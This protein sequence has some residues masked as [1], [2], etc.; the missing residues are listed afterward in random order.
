[1]IKTII[2]TGG[3]SSGHVTPNLAL[4]K[5]AEQRGWSIHYL[6]ANGI[7]KDI[8]GK[9]NIPYHEIASGKLRRY[10][11]WQNFID[12]FKI[13]YAIMQSFF[14]LR[15]IKPHCV[16]SKGGFVAVPVVIAAW[17][18]RIPVIA[19]E[20]D[21]TPGLANKLCYPFV[22]VLC[23]SFEETKHFI[24]AHPK[25]LHTGTPLRAELFKGLPEKG[26]R[27]CGFTKDKPILF[28][29]CGGLGSKRINHS[30]WEALPRLLP[31]FQVIHICGKGNFNPNVNPPG[32]F[33]AEYLYE[34]F[35]DCLACA[36]YVISRSGANSVFELLALKKLA[37]FIPLALGSRG[38]QVHNA[39]YCLK[40]GLALVLPEKE[41]TPQALCDRLESLKINRQKLLENLQNLK[42]PNAAGK[43][44]ALFDKEII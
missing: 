33:Q 13:F 20:S 1:M 31:D 30:V 15:K 35:A 18:Q 42:T 10:F 19:H 6:G 26:L 37:L 12:P 5:E 11:S 3:G 24:S 32:Y 7:E 21:Y 8:I 23:I 44:M 36:D 43:I 2:F 16:F 17:L 25:I 39:D 29:F 22:K 34:D 40:K 27:L 41:L 9:T 14:L 28:I 4:I 38:D